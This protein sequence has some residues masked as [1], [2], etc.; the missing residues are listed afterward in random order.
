MV[1]VEGRGQ[2]VQRLI[3]REVQGGSGLLQQGAGLG[4]Q[5]EGH[6]MQGV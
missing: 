5:E 4:T 6:Q 2:E 3:P 1:G